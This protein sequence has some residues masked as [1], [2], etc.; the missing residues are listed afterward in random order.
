MTMTMRLNPVAAGDLDSLRQ[1]DDVP[2]E[3][4]DYPSCD[5]DQM[6]DILDALLGADPGSPASQ[7]VSGGVPFG[8]NQ[9][10]G[11]PRTLRPDEVAAVATA[12]SLLTVAEMR[13]RFATVDMTDRYQ[14]EKWD[15]DGVY[16]AFQA[17]RTCYSES[18]AA[19]HAMALFM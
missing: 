8:E 17:L 19:G 6:W 7:A 11:P 9:G 1:Q 4:Y 16:R 18:A 12:L 5:L 13:N 3:F 14:A 15:F 10:F 2:L